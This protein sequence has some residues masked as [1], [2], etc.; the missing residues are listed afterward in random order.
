MRGAVRVRQRVRFAWPDWP[1]G[2]AS[3]AGSEILAPARVTNIRVFPPNL[4]VNKRDVIFL[5]AF[6]F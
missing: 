3:G 2:A 1:C 5:G 6:Y 4:G